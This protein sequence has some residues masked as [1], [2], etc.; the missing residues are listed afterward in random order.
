MG[1]QLYHEDFM[2]KFRE[3][4]NSEDYKVKS[5]Y[6]KS[7]DKV[8]FF[9]KKCGNEFEMKA[10]NFTN[11]QRCPYCYGRKIYTTEE[12]AKRIKDLTNGEY[13]LKSE[14]VNSH[15]KVRILHKGCKN[16]Y[17]AYPNA[18]IQGVRCSFCS[19]NKKLTIDKVKE[20]V[21][22][23]SNDTYS[24]KSKSY[25]NVH[26]LIEFVHNECKNTFEMSYNNFRN[27]QRCPHCCN[28]RNSRAIKNI[29]K[30]L[31]DLDFQYEKE[32]T[33]KGLVNPN[34]GK[35]LRIDFFLPEIDLYIEYDGKQHSEFSK[36]GIFT[37]RKFKEL[38]LRDDIK[39][40]YFKKNKLT[41]LRIKYPEK[42]L[43]ILENYLLKNNYIE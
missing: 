38:K 42:E 27:G 34:T 9:H 39:D 26:G 17:D 8:K 14:Y 4:P 21:S 1:K 28:L 13:I 41:L 33:L 6:T 2:I 31:K 30:Y 43:D 11:G 36:R 12:F 7:R 32:V 3:L 29:S 22:K 16:I 40:N 23:I 24:V 35:K 19:G 5:K 37:E 20:N 10:N 15:T 18:F 25:K